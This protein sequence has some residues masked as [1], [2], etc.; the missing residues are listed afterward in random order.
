MLS[1]LLV[2]LQ[3]PPV[4]HLFCDGEAV[5]CGCNGMGATRGSWALWL[6]F[7]R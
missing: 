2:P 6:L 3:R 5:L 4:L 1:D 7:G